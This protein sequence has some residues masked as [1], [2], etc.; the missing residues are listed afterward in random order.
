MS[1]IILFLTLCAS[2]LVAGLPPGK[3]LND[4]P[5]LRARDKTIDLKQ[6]RGQPLVIAIVS[7]M[8]QECKDIITLLKKL[9][10][11]N[12]KLQVVGVVA[13]EAAQ[14]TSFVF[15]GEQ[16][17]GFPIGYVSLEGY[18]K[19]ANLKPQQAAHSPILLFVDPKG[20]VR[21]QLFG[22]DPLMKKP[23]LIVRGT[24]RELLAESTAS[25]KK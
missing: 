22:D 3:P 13:E 17:A 16:D 2:L 5:V 4:V 12:P 15:A 1:R 9:R 21:V 19:L 8:C 23:D 20:M 25:A 24:V 18:Q 14:Y 6:Y 10:A 7:T 11:E